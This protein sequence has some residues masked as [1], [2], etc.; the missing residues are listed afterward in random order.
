MPKG[1]DVNFLMIVRLIGNTVPV[2]LGEVTAIS[3][4]NT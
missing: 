2:R 4:P 3:S 1:E